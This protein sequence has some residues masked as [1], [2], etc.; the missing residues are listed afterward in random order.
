MYEHGF[1]D[2]MEDWNYDD[3]FGW[4]ESV[5]DDGLGC[6][7]ID[8]DKEEFEN[9]DSCERIGFRYQT[10]NYRFLYGGVTV[11]SGKARERGQGTC[12]EMLFSPDNHFEEARDSKEISETFC[13]QHQRILHVLKNP[14]VKKI[15]PYS[16]NYLIEYK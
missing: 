15:T 7:V 2:G 13:A 1:T 14:V 9:H 4:C 16:I 10:I 12:S 5:C 6:D 3:V 11:L 8:F